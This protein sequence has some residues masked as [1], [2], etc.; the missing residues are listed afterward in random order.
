MSAWRPSRRALIAA[1]ASF[2][3][4]A[5]LGPSRVLAATGS[6]GLA[7]TEAQLAAGSAFLLRHPS[8]D[9]HAHPGLFFLQDAVDPT[10]RM[11]SFGVPFVDKALADLRGGRVTAALFAGVA[12]TRLLDFSPTRGL[13]AT[14]EFA[15]GEAWADYRRQITV[16]KRLVARRV[17]RKGTRK[18]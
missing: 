11:V 1:G 18:C 2:G 10:R 6:L 5:S 12:D 8:V 7:L 9:L 17:V 13:F 3:L 14:R 4:A 15:P 16:L